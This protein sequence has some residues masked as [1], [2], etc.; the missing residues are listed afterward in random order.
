[1]G[2]HPRPFADPGDGHT[3]TT[4]LAAWFAA[5]EAAITH[6]SPSTEL[7]ADTETYNATFDPQSIGTVVADMRGAQPY[8]SDFLSFSYD[9]YDSPLQ[10][11]PLYDETYRDYVSAGRVE[12]TPPTTP[13]GLTA[14]ALNSFSIALSWT[15][16][17]R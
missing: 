11:G 5:T 4:Q 9:H 17:H 15:A 16:R 8:V 10:V 1:M 13:T 2:E 6:A 14:T 12:S 7:W 3:S